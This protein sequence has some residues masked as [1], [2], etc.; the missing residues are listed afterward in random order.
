MRPQGSFLKDD[1]GAVAVVTI[2][3]MVAFFA[4]V[5]VVV[6]LGHLMLVRGQIQNAADA[7][8]LAGAGALAPY[9]SSGT[10]NWTTGTNVALTTVQGNKADTQNLTTA[11][12]QTGYW[13]LTL[14]SAQPL[15]PTGTVIVPGSTLV[16]AVQVIV[17]KT[18]SN[19]GPVA[20]T[21]GQIFGISTVN[22]GAHATAIALITAPAGTLFP[23]AI[24]LA[25]VTPPS[26]YY[27]PPN[28]G[29][30]YTFNIGS[31]YHYPSDE[32]G[33]W[34]TFAVDSDN[35][36]TVR[37]LMAN[38]NPN[39]VS[40]GGDIWVEPGTKTTLF[41]DAAAYVGKTA[42]LPVVNGNMTTHA[43]DPVLGFIPFYITAAVG[44]SGKYVQGYFS[45]G[46]IP[47]GSF[48]TYLQPCLVK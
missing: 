39:S 14:T 33:Q 22:V 7:G 16:P 10:P 26:P 12:V 43:F 27:N 41:G 11:T 38:G 18:P 28:F 29:P 19:N 47:P 5:A 25:M 17:Q 15:Q 24:G 42:L 44:G 23:I 2:I 46:I 9:T 6:D 4:L 1:R 37:G 3:M 30:A 32:A 45:S 8:A 31:D 13:D 21:F 36:P 40:V 35:V 48:G 20:L 34:T